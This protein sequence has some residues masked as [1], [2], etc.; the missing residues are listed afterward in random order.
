MLKNHTDSNWWRWDSNFNLNSNIE[1]KNDEF[2][3]FL[4]KLARTV[5]LCL[6]ECFSYWALVWPFRLRE[7]VQAF[8]L[9]LTL[10]RLLGTVG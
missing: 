9:L 4:K 7:V 3:T 5:F 2:Y 8:R 1:F 10:S 6:K